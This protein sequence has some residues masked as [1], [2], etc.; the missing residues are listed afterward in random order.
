MTKRAYCV[1]RRDTPE[2]EEIVFAET[3]GQAKSKA[4]HLSDDFLDLVCRRD[5]RFD[6]Y[7]DTE[8]VPIAALVA[9]GWR[10]ECH[11]AG[12]SAWVLA[13]DEDP[14]ILIDGKPYCA[15]CAANQMEKM[16]DGS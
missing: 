10:F 6:R 2:H 1:H 16:V 11:G 13:D 4:S 7:A 3:P 8:T 12:C 15:R 14:V 5:A 9:A